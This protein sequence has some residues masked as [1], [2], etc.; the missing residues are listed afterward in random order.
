M[1]N[2]GNCLTRMAE[3]LEFDNKTFDNTKVA[4][5]LWHR[6]LDQIPESTYKKLLKEARREVTQLL[7]ATPHSS[8][9]FKLSHKNIHV[10]VHWR[11]L[12]IKQLY[13]K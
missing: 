9:D 8:G 2:F 11:L 5:N 3:V 1:R 12:K 6:D 4:V 13:A 10:D 7:K